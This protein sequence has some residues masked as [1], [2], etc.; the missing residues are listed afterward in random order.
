[1]S[2]IVENVREMRTSPETVVDLSRV[3]AHQVS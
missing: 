3:V 2:A 1:M